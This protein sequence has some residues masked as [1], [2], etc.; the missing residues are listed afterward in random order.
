MSLYAMKHEN[1]PTCRCTDRIAEPSKEP[2]VDADKL[3]AELTRHNR[4]TLE[5][6]SK[7]GLL[8]REIANAP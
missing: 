7:G 1:C 4:A 5:H 6:V 2:P 8:L 3:A